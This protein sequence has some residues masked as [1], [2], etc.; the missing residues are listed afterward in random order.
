MSLTV[1]VRGT[2]P[3]CG[4]CGL[5]KPSWHH[6]HDGRAYDD[7]AVCAEYRATEH[8]VWKCRCGYR[9]ATPTADSAAHPEQP[10]SEGTTQP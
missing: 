10:D 7:L 4:L 8:V 3:K 2:C 6:I 9:A 5:S 1:K